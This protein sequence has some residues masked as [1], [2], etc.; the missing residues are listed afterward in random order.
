MADELIQSGYRPLTPQELANQQ[1]GIDRQR[2]IAEFLQQQSFQSPEGQMVSGH[3]VAPSFLQNLSRIAQGLIGKSQQE[4]LDEKQA[5]ILR[6]NGDNLFKS[7]GGNIP[8]AA[9]SNSQLTNVAPQSP[10]INLDQP[11]AD[12]QVQTGAVLPPDNISRIAAALTGQKTD[13]PTATQQSSGGGYFDVPGMTPEQKF[14]M[15]SNDPKGYMSLFGKQFEPTELQKNSKWMGISPEVRRV[16]EL[17]EMKKKG[18]LEMQPGN[19]VKNLADG[20]STVVPDFKTGIAGGFDVFGNP[21]MNKIAGS[22]AIAEL[23]GDVK[24]AEAAAAAGYNM[25]KVDTVD[26]PVLMTAEQ[27][28][29]IASGGSKSSAQNYPKNNTK[30]NDSEFARMATAI[31]NNPESSAADKADAKQWFDAHPNF[32]QSTQG[33]PLQ[34]DEDREAK[35]GAVKVKNAV[36]EQNLKNYPEYVVK[37]QTALTSADQAIKSIEKLIGHPGLAG[38]TGLQGTIDPR[39]YIPGTDA[40]NARTLIDQVKG[41]TYLSAYNDLRGAGAITENEGK[42]ATDAKARLDRAQSTKEYKSALSELKEILDNSVKRLHSTPDP[43]DLSRNR[44]LSNPNS[45]NQ[46]N[47]NVDYEKLYGVKLK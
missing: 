9:N 16:A 39:N 18:M 43:V 35:V 29:R 45:N 1:A 14:A 7:F 41:Q 26:G 13:Q 36:D 6:Q 28:A 23:A 17:A 2:K 47:M 34:T 22:N 27:A 32:K 24:R 3:Y 10:Q 46:Q 40:R 44:S 25:T 11:L 20:T 42:A 38:A 15:Y 4:A 5:N 21:V 31:L 8:Q 37:K 19:V 30:S 33:I 12:G